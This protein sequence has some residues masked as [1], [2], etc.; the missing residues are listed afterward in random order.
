MWEQTASSK[1]LLLL[2]FLLLQCSVRVAMAVRGT[3]NNINR[4]HRRS[5]VT[6]FELW[7]AATKEKIVTL[8]D[9]TSI[10]MQTGGFNVKAVVE[11]CIGS[12]AVAHNGQRIHHV[13]NFHP[14]FFCADLMGQPNRCDTLV[15]GEHTIKVTPYAFRYALGP[16]ATSNSISF[17]IVPTLKKPV[18]SDT[19]LGR[20]VVSP[21]ATT[22]ATTTQP[23]NTVIV[24]PRNISQPVAAPPVP[25]TPPVTA[26][27]NRRPT[28][29]APNATT[30]TA[31][32][33]ITTTTTST[34]STG[35]F[36]TIRINCGGPAHTDAE[37]NIWMADKYYV[38]QKGVDSGAYYL[39]GGVILGTTEE[40][41]FQSE[42]WG[43]F[44]YEIP[45][46]PGDYQVIL[47]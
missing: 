16:A 4:G 13:E 18:T 23:D 44:K 21:A 8:V 36:A 28:A 32:T 33:T 14:Y 35:D 26:V 24:P 11:M 12:L 34:S 6:S 10:P 9:G 25:I 43:L 3:N 39:E 40:E 30:T 37:G 27:V 22:T 46:P 29:N 15:E 5:V 41:L 1:A 20:D 7:D 19:D 47:Q 17:T 2:L 45:V 31:T 38:V 42:R